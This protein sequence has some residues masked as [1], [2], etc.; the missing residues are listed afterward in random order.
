MKSYL[1]TR[2]FLLS[3]SWLVNKQFKE[4]FSIH[5]LNTNDTSET[6]YK[7]CSKI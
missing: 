5:L 4:V 3:N 6:R 2:K 7:F 1:L